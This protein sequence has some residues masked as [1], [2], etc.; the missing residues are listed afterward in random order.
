[1]DNIVQH[2]TDKMLAE[3]AVKNFLLQLSKRSVEMKLWNIIQQDFNTFENFEEG[4]DIKKMDFS[5]FESEML[6]HKNIAD[7]NESGGYQI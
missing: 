1:M 3:I 4:M 6:F 5:E 7:K 2:P